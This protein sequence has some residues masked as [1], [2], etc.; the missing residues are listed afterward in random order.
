MK[1]WGVWLED[2]SMVMNKHLFI[3]SLAPKTHVM[4]VII[5]SS[6]RGN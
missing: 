4:W 2:S 6:A 3:Q 1:E 5:T